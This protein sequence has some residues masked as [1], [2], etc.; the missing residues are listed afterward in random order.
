VR[1]HR[2]DFSIQRFTERI[3]GEAQV[4]AVL[5]VQPEVRSGA[6]GGVLRSSPARRKAVSAV[7]ARQCIAALTLDDLMDT[8]CRNAHAGRQPAEIAVLG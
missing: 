2:D 5:Q 7:M 1:H 6:D 4:V 8:G 3:L